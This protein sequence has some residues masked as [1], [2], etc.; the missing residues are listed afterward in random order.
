V[1]D[2]NPRIVVIVG[3]TATGKSSLA[4][5]LARR[6]GGEIVGVDSIQVYRGLD[7][8]S[9]KPS[10][11]IMREIPH[12]LI[13]V[14]RP[15]DDFSA[16]DFARLAE[17]AIRGIAGRGRVP[18]L[19]GGTGLY[20]R[21]LLRG[22]AEM[23]PRDAGLREALKAIGRSRGEG[24]LHHML[25]VL[26]PKRAAELPP[27]D[28]QRVVRALEVAFATG[29]PQSEWLAVQPFGPDMYRAVKVGLTM[30]WPL[31][32]ARIDA[33]VEEMFASGL[34]EETAALLRSG[35]PR[36]ANCF[37]ALGYREILE[38]LAGG[39]GENETKALVKLN[40]R[41]YAKRQL[42]WF[43]R[44]PDVVWF[45][46]GD[47]PEESYPGIEAEIARQISATESRDGDRHA[48]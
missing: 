15:G 35:V 9:A 28:T 37:K 40:T 13:D 48:R 24:S 11:A 43:R 23:P 46:L 1:A 4:A 25:E 26:D 8:G 41:R 7:A 27:R 33:R 34:V 14:A 18:I 20:L 29:R 45:R 17:E 3:P 12:H 5:H 22:I 44:E 16:G 2:T 32:E 30:D 10:P 19:A 31:L 47:R 21:A 39:A 36:S 38:M 6:L 42:T